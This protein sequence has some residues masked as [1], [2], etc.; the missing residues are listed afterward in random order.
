LC[1]GAALPELA[2]GTKSVFAYGAGTVRNFRAILT[3]FCI[4]LVPIPVNF[5]CAA[6]LASGTNVSEIQFE[7]L[8]KLFEANGFQVTHGAVTPIEAKAGVT[9]LDTTLA[10]KS[11]ASDTSPLQYHFDKLTLQGLTVD[12]SNISFDSL[13]ADKIDVGQV[14]FPE[15]SHMRFDRLEIA[16]GLI[17]NLA[18]LTDDPNRPIS[19]DIAF[20]RL[21][22]TAK[23]SNFKVDGGHLSDDTS[24][25]EASISGVADGKITQSQV[26]NYAGNLVGEAEG[27]QTVDKI[28]IKNIDL[29]PFLRMFEASAYLEAGVTRPWR[30]F[31]EQFE[32]DGF[33]FL[34]GTTDVKIAS[35]SL[36]PIRVHQFDQNLTD[37]FDKAVLDPDFKQTQPVQS[38]RIQA[39]LRN[40]FIIDAM[41]IEGTELEVPSKAGRLKGSITSAAVSG[42]TMKH[43][44]GLE[45]AGFDL[46]DQTGSIALGKFLLA[47]IVIPDTAFGNLADVASGGVD[48]TESSTLP[49]IG[50]VSLEDL[51]VKLSK[52]AFSVGKFDLSMQFFIDAIPTN[53]AVKFDHLKMDLAS[54]KIPELQE[55]FSALGYKNIDVSAE[56]SG[57]WHDSASA[58]AINSISV[59][60]VDMGKLAVSGTVTG[61]SRASFQNPLGVF[62]AEI[63]ASGVENFRISFENWSLFD[64]II[65][66]FGKQN[67]I[68]TDEIKN[69]LTQNMPAIMND[70][71]SPDIR[72]K[73]IF[74]AVSFLNDPKILEISSSTGDVVTVKEIVNAWA[75]PA[76]LPIIMNLDAS[77]NDRKGE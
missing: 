33:K 58:V 4:A 30:N 22:T 61:I 28:L 10:E 75:Q 13:V 26:L 1:C 67:N 44:D 32:F 17:P 52:F 23:I 5:A 51:S 69:V 39:A 42:F 48:K 40:S 21:L 50:R 43:V 71:Q 59:S 55:L 46:S 63:A 24:F 65:A 16:G 36:G 68:S 64:R 45:F 41:K 70:I 3:G 66:L 38:A 54:L 37:L 20:L 27:S 8:L 53:V 11:S 62:P 25:T 9:V 12:D 31:V 34:S 73:F 74:A 60:G 7:K 56:V 18:K 57:A 6:N 35:G 47:N 72:N 14:G 76:K 49:R 19:S 2:A 15:A 29:D 77:A